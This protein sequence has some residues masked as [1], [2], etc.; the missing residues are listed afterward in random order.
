MEIPPES[1]VTALP[2]STTGAESPPPWC[3]SAMKYGSLEAERPT[4]ASPVSPSSSMPAR[5]RTTSSIPYFSEILR[6]ICARYSGVATLEGS[7][8][9]SRANTAPSATLAPSSAPSVASSSSSSSATSQ[10]V[11]RS[12][13]SAA[14]LCL[15]KRYRPSLAPS[16]T[17]REISLIA[18]SGMAGRENAAVCSPKALARLATVAAA[19]EAGRR[20]TLPVEQGRLARFSDEISARHDPGCVVAEVPRALPFIQ[21]YR[22]QLWHEFLSCPA[23]SADGDQVRTTLPLKTLDRTDY[24]GKGDAV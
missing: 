24:R 3:S 8:A 14:L 2:M 10:N 1:N 13:S 21:G 17:V 18:V 12:C 9:R 7:L 16:A 5:S 4:V 19:Q 6:A 11:S 22:E 15:S 23:H 20:S